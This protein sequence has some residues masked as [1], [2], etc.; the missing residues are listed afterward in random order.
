[1]TVQQVRQQL[2]G[3]L[4]HAGG[5]ESVAGPERGHHRGAVGQEA[6]AVH[7]GVAEV[8]AQG[9]P[10]RVDRLGEPVGDQ[11]ERAVPPDLL[12]HRLRGSPWGDPP[13]RLPQAVPVVVHVRDG[14]ALGADVPAGQRVVGVAAHRRHPALFDGQLEAADR[15]AQVADRQPLPGEVRSHRAAPELAGDHPGRPVGPAVQGA[16]QWDVHASHRASSGAARP[17][18]IGTRTGTARRGRY[19]KAPASRRR[20]WRQSPWVT[21]SESPSWRS[22]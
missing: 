21:E 8:D 15:L 5:G 18:V 4:V 13:Y 22:G 9:V 10:V 20:K 19:P 7:V 12:P 1:M 3:Q 17:R 14:H 11:V 16:A 2:V 6:Q